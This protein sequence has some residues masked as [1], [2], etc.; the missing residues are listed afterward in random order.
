M[1]GPSVELVDAAERTG[2]SFVV[3]LTSLHSSH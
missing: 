1:I 2:H 3:R